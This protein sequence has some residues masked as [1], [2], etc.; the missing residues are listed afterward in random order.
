MTE[1]VDVIRVGGTAESPRGPKRRMSLRARVSLLA[2]A[3]VA[4]VM[5]L[6]S[7]GAYITVYNNLYQQVDDNLANRAV[8]AVRTPEAQIGL[9]QIP[10]AFLLSTDMQIGVLNE[11]GTMSAP[12]RS[13]RPP[14]G[15]DELA[16]AQGKT[17][18]SLRTDTRTDT[19]VI[20]LP[21]QDGSAMVL[22]QPL[23]SV[24]QT[25]RELAVVLALIGGGGII[26]AALAGTAVART[27]LRPVER[28]TSATERV[29]RTG[30]LRPIPVSGDDELARLTHSF[31]TMLGTVAES[32]ERQRQ[33]VA[34]AGHELRT[35]LTSL[36][37]NL[38]LLLSAS[39]AGAPALSEKDR[40][41]METDIK[42]Q[43]DELTQ[44]IGDLVELARQ[45][46]PRTEYER[47]ELADVV[48]RALDRARR[49]AVDID[50]QVDLQPWVL[51]GDHWA[52]ERAVLNLLDNAV[53]FSPAGSTVRVR[54]FPLGDGTAVI[55]VGDSGPGIADVDLPKVFERFYRSSEARTLPGSGL[56]LAIV[57][58]A[59]ER[60]GG[61]VYA[62]RAPEGGALMSIRLPGAPG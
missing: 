24:K 37:T 48:E 2:A 3:C 16:V 41:D 19:R 12:D 14:F 13:H 25:L 33:L 49:R 22:A 1:P 10:G 5:A 36:R 7:I 39:R 61:T 56:G 46:E 15:S 34:D 60:H 55:E 11:D 21:Y 20:A 30:D 62:G 58:Q 8:A 47:V 29:A 57:K 32:Q 26:V 45:D 52:L 27:G 35:P 31:N 28:L 50:F 17:S 53:K 4:V 38:E 51:T 59:A 9:Q 23:A 44:L 18:S 54:L 42:A 43:L 6:V 40:A